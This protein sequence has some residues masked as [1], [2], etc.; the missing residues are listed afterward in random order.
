[1]ERWKEA[2]NGEVVV[3]WGWFFGVFLVVFDVFVDFVGL[4]V[5]SCWFCGA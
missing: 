1:M 3:F 5:C 2:R 4:F